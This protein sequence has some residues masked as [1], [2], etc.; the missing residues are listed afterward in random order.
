M[1]K[2]QGARCDW[3]DK[4]DK[5][6]WQGER[7][8]GG[9]LPRGNKLT[10]SDRNCDWG[11]PEYLQIADETRNPDSDRVPEFLRFGKEEAPMTTCGII[12]FSVGQEGGSIH[13]TLYHITGGSFTGSTEVRASRERADT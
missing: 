9:R 8:M 2:L 10:I 3:R 7:G 5:T 6:S 4:R 1:Y 11:N 13:V 12:L